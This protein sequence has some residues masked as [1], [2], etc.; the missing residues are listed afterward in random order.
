MM[1]DYRILEQDNLSILYLKGG[2]TALTALEMKGVIHDLV[3]E[4]HLRVVI[5]FSNLEVID[6]SGVGAIV[7]LFKRIRALQGDVKVVGLHGQPRDIFKL[8]GLD[9]AFDVVDSYIEVVEKF[10][11]MLVSTSVSTTTS[12]STSTSRVLVS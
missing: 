4:R 11:H 1:F 9:K 2:L 6:S 5:D 10:R 8:L 7:S 3:S 12:A